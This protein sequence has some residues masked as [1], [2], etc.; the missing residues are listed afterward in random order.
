MQILSNLS[1]YGTLGLN[2]VADANT[3]TDKFLVIDSSGIVKYRTGAELYNDIGAGGAAAYTSVLQHTVKA[4]VALTKGQAVYVTSADGTNMIVGKASN[5]SEA[6]S[7]KTLGLIVQDLAINDQGFVITEG[8]LAGLDTSTAAAGDPVWL[9]TDGNLI[10]GLLNK[11][12]APDHLVFIGIVTR[13]QQN[14]GEIFVKVQN[15]FELQELHNVQITS[16]PSDN[17]VLAYETSTSLYKMKSIPTL[18]GYT[19]VTNARSITI[20]GTTYDLSADRSWSVGTHTGNLTT[21]YVPK[22]TGATTLTDS[23]IYDNGSGIGINTSSPY[24]SSAFKL[25]VNG[26]LLIKNTSGTTAQLILINSN[27][28]T[29]GN[30]GFVQLSAGGNTDTA[31]GQWQTY[32]GMSVAAGALRLQPAGGQVLIGTTTTSAF[33]TDINGTLR[34]SGQLTLGSTISNN[35]YVYTMPG[36]SGTLALVSQIPSLSGYLTI[37]SADA[38]YLTQSSAASIYLSQTSAS[39]TYLTISGASSTYLS[40]ANASNTY[41]TIS[42]ASSI[43]LSQTSASNTYL[44]INSASSIYLSQTSASNTYL[45]INNAA[46]TYVSLTG[47]YANPSWI[48]SLGWSKIT[49]APAFITSYTETDTLA[50]VTARGASTTTRT[51]FTEVGATRAGSDTVAVGPWFRWTNVAE[52]RQMLVQL[53]ASNGLTYWSYN[54]SAWATALVLTQAGAATFSSSITTTGASIG[55]VVM[56][57]DG[58]DSWFRMQSGNRMRITTTGGTDFI[59]PNTGNMTYNGNTVW[60]SGNLTNLSQLTNGPG[61][62]TSLPSHNH[63]GVY[64]KTNRTLDTIN[65]IDNGGDRYNPSVNNPTNEHYA[66]LTYG[67]GGNV[68]GQLATHFVSGQLYSRG[69]N[70]S[71]STWLKYVV[72]NGG[73]WNINI[74]GNSASA[75]NLGAD[76]TADDWFRATADNNPVKFYGNSYQ[77]TWR[78][79]GA[80]EAYSGIGAYPFVWTYGGSSTG[81]RIM[82]LGTSGDLWT[83]SYGWLHNYFQLA[84]SAINTSNIASQSVNYASSAGNADTVDSLHASSFVRRDTTGQF[85][86]PYQEYGSY[87]SNSTL[88]N[89]LVSNMGGG[90]LRVDF[91]NG[92]SFGTW[93]HVI[94]FSGY[95]GYNM[96]QLAGHY[97]GSGSSGPDLYVRNEPNHEQTSWSSWARLL[98]TSSD[99]Y[100]SNMNQYVRSTDNVTFAQV[101]ASN[102]YASSDVRGNDV[103]TTGGWFRNHTNSNGIYWSTTGWHIYPKDT[104]DIYVRSGASDCSIHMVRNGTSGNYIHCSSSDHIGFLSTGRSWTFR[105]ENGGNAQ[106]YGYLGVGQAPNT[107]YRVITSGDYYANAGGNYWAEGRFKQYRGSGT[108]HDVID[109]G[110]IGSQSVNY[111][112]YSGYADRI[113]TGTNQ[114]VW[115]NGAHTVT[116]PN[117]VTLWDQYSN[118]GGSGNPTSY[119]TILDIYGRSDHEHDQLY[120]SYDGQLLH[121]NCFYGTNSWSGWRTILNDSQ[122]GYA[123]RMN[124]DVR[125][126]D[127][128]EFNQVSIRAAL[129]VG[130]YGNSSDI[131]MTDGDEGTRRIHCNSNRVGFLNQSSSWGAYCDDAGNW[132][133]DFDMYCNTLNTGNTINI[134]FTRNNES[135]STSSFRGIEFHAPGNRDYYLGKPEGAWTQPLHVHFYTGIWLRSHQSYGGIRF[136]NIAYDSQL[137]SVGDGSD[138]VNVYTNQYNDGGIY[139][140]RG[141][142]DY[143]TFIRAQN[144]PDAGYS[145]SDAKYWVE[146]GSYGGVHVTL[147]MDGSAGSGENGYDHFTIWQAAANSSSGSRQFYVTNIGNVWARNDITAFSDI[148]VKENIRPIENALQKVVNSRGVMYDRIDT[149]EK[150]GIGFIAQELETQIPDLVKTDDKGFKSVKYQNMVAILT[151]AIKEQQKQIEELQNKLD[152]VTK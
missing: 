87:I 132:I 36:A 3:D 47:S 80:S 18:L 79:D 56:D 141:G 140:K 143:S 7:S 109:S 39:N 64:M 54:G 139:F 122:H 5:A 20:N 83:N 130:T 62:L 63:D 77:M 82:L 89:E 45:T 30:N 100:P 32:Y 134:G 102:I 138:K 19:P 59:I 98:N 28:A 17:A 145:S 73:T 125:A 114:W 69:Y 46:S 149:G 117:T 110:N 58:T 107:S 52:D 10:Y 97:K 88:P 93:S 11:P 106:V 53:N 57:Y 9:G 103:Y 120:F 91:L 26:G 108:W 25:D 128:V 72:E 105:V 146:L 78:T 12:Y 43:Y 14:N 2:S 34:V 136:Y 75:T 8:L 124:Q 148:R 49:G 15:G 96:Y 84:S 74:S 113:Q 85:L 92:A 86:K 150:N 21:G 119:G 4:G 71:W 151:E 22:A 44:S 135:I 111:A 60:H 31:F 137:F 121:R 41:L 115:S 142:S 51:T 1:L 68:T 101:N 50:T 33:L 23:L 55:R 152:A 126:S 112:N 127:N 48:T 129:Y 70:S 95:N 13:A 6:T 38:T 27:P 90:G 116:N 66:V 61:Y 67:N 24:E 37:A 81:N 76:Y 40:Q 99:P 147:N 42:G 65:T 35:T 131:Y 29:G 94:T 123:A 133:T 144:H 16:T 118:Y 104:S